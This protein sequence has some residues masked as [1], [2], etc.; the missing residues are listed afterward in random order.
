VG[1]QNIYLSIHFINPFSL[2][3]NI[4]LR[5]VQISPKPCF[6]FSGCV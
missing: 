5:Y 3:L 2:I 4:A 6:W 1:T